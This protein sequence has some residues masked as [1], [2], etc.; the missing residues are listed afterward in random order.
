MMGKYP[1]NKYATEVESELHDEIFKDDI[2]AW[3]IDEDVFSKIKK[4][5]VSMASK[6]NI[7]FGDPILDVDF[8]CN[9]IYR[10]F[11]AERSVGNPQ[12]WRKAKKIHEI[13]CLRGDGTI[14]AA[15]GKVDLD[16]ELFSM[17][18]DGLREYWGEIEKVLSYCSK[19]QIAQEIEAM[20]RE[21][22][23]EENENDR[24]YFKHKFVGY[25]KSLKNSGTFSNKV[26]TIRDPEGEFLYDFFYFLKHDPD[27]SKY[28]TRNIPIEWENPGVPKRSEKRKKIDKYLK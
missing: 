21:E 26:K 24:K 15:T 11:F 18:K 28:L 22:E 17:M 5:M 9:L 4:P 13:F 20:A 23:R 12:M 16:K 14:K 3:W 8:Y 27:L 7:V 25:I 10:D 19:N 6:Y 2:D 1:K